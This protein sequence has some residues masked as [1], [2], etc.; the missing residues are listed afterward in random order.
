MGGH[1]HGEGGGGGQEGPPRG[2]RSSLGRVTLAGCAAARRGRRGPVPAVDVHTEVSCLHLF[3]GVEDVDE[4]KKT[5]VDPHACDVVC[6]GTMER[7]EGSR[8]ASP[9]KVMEACT[10]LLPFLAALFCWSCNPKIKNLHLHCFGSQIAF[11]LG[12]DKDGLRELE[13]FMRSLGLFGRRM[14]PSFVTMGALMNEG[15]SNKKRICSFFSFRWMCQDGK[16]GTSCGLSRW[17][18]ASGVSVGT[19][20]FRSFFSCASKRGDTWASRHALR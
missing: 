8:G 13:V 16:A 14:K 5:L 20:A 17:R 11:F 4:K 19:F 15:L 10:F 12:N 1:G 7:R 18:C 9:G 6:A 2:W 3:D